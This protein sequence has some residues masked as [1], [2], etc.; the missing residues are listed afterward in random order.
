MAA[1]YNYLGDVA[2]LVV[3][4]TGGGTGLGL[5]IS[6]ALALNGAKVYITGRRREKLEEAVKLV[7]NGNIIPIQGSVT[8][9]EDLQA[10]VDFITKDSGYIDVLVANAGMTTYDSRPDARPKPTAQ[11]T[12]SEIRDYYFNYRSADVWKDC[13]ETNTASVFTTSMAFLELL[14]AGSRC[15]TVN[16]NTLG[17]AT[18]DGPS[19]QTSEGPKTSRTAR[20]SRSE[21]LAG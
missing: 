7:G 10:A 3:V 9:R 6:K 2:G 11:S 19:V 17:D 16:F 18:A 12:L 1:N 13:L 8:S 14:D 15:L 4:V 20:L 21:A 5:M